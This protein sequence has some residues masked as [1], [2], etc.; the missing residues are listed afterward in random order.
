[1][2]EMEENIAESF[3]GKEVWVDFFKGKEDNNG[4]Q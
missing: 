2:Q 3:L 4:H 1:M